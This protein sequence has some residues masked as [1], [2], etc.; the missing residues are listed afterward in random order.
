MSLITYAITTAAQPIVSLAQA[1]AYLGVAANDTSQDTVVQAMVD[2]ATA[3]LDGPGGWLGRFLGEQ[4]VQA[5]I[6]GTR[7]TRNGPIVLC[8]P[9]QSLASVEGL[10]SA[11][12]LSLDGDALLGCHIPWLWGTPLPRPFVVNYVAGSDPAPPQAVMAILV[13]CQ[14]MFSLS[15]RDA[16]LKSFAAGDTKK[17]WGQEAGTAFDATVLSIVAPLRVWR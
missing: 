14:R 4:T 16:G 3:F 12:N 6:A 8:G 15:S 2:A 1:K 11:S 13:A 9:V 7:R 10:G 5:T 17:E